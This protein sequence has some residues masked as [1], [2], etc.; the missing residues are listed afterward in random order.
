MLPGQHRK[1][2]IIFT[3]CSNCLKSIL[4]SWGFEG[5]C[6][7]LTRKTQEDSLCS[8]VSGA[9]YCP[10]RPSCVT[11]QCVIRR[12]VSTGARARFPGMRPEPHQSSGS[13]RQAGVRTTL[14][15]MQVGISSCKCLCRSQKFAFHQAWPWLCRRFT[16]F[17]VCSRTLCSVCWSV[18]GVLGSVSGCSARF[19]KSITIQVTGG[20]QQH[21]AVC[22]RPC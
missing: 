21:S 15:H 22:L 18:G 20:S 5:T 10:H 17:C 13:G 9:V 8:D 19:L 16:S 3:H 6:V 1:S 12:C 4:L 7:N 11:P 14:P 2:G